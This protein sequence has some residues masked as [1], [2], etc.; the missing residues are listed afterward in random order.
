MT[1]S[2]KRVV[3]GGEEEVIERVLLFSGLFL[4]VGLEGKC[5]RARDNLLVT[6]TGANMLSHSLPLVGCLTWRRCGRQ[7]VHKTQKFLVII[8]GMLYTSGV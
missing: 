1:P 4:S 5:K 3:G 8:V 7:S 6:E 2:N